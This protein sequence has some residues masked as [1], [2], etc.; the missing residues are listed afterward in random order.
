MCRTARIVIK[1]HEG[2]AESKTDYCAC[3]PMVRV[4][5]ASSIPLGLVRNRPEPQNCAKSPV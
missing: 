3:L 1:S 5:P 4:V 2:R